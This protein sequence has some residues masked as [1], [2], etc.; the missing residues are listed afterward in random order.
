MKSIKKDHLVPVLNSWAQRFRLFAP[1]RGING[2]FILSHFQKPNFDLDYKK[3]S[4]P[5]KSTLMPQSEVIFEVENNGYREVVNAP[6]TMLFGI[7]ACDAAGLVQFAR[8]MSRDR[9]DVYTKSRTDETIKVVMACDGPQTETCFCTTTKSG[10][11]AKK[12]FDLQFYDIGDVFLVETGSPRAEA[13]LAEKSF[14]DQDDGKAAKQIK[15][16]KEKGVRA[17]P[18]RET[19]QKAMDRL[20]EGKAVENVWERLGKKCIACGGCVY[21]CPTCTC[22]NVYDEVSGPGR[23]HRMRS[24]DTCLFGGFTREAS[25]HNPRPDQNSRLQRR[26]EHK[27]LYYHRDDVADML[28]GCVGCGRCSDY[29]PVHIGTLEVVDAISGQ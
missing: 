24:W 25:G 3:P 9:E 17:I 28:C 7:R 1:V 2:E 21:V 16:F 4:L 13:L 29:C 23:G 5:P 27:L 11:Y 19:V 14:F 12:G 20:K 8:F 10:P 22:F 6:Q 15:G 26:H 18:V